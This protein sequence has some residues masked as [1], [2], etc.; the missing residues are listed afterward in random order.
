MNKLLDATMFILGLVLS[1]IGIA[2]IARLS[3]IESDFKQLQKNIETL[4]SN[5]KIDC[6]SKGGMLVDSKCLYCNVYSKGIELCSY[7]K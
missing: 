3:T 5:Y 4:E 1:M 6:L 7:N 2:N